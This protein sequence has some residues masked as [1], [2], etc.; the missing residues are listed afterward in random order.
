MPRAKRLGEK[1]GPTERD[2][3]VGRS[4]QKREEREFYR[5]ESLPAGADPRNKG[6]SAEG[7]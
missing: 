5:G 6:R 1:A 7:L 4:K 2:R 3:K